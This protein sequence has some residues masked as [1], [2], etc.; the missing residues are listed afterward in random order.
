MRKFFRKSVYL[1]AFEIQC[2]FDIDW[3]ILIRLYKNNNETQNIL[4][5]SLFSCLCAWSFSDREKGLKSKL[6]SDSLFHIR[7]MQ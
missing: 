4:K 1:N 2:V 5:I 6:F 7:I 3:Q